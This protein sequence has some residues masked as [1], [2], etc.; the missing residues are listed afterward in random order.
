MYPSRRPR[1]GGW[2]QLETGAEPASASM[3]L[4]VFFGSF[5][6]QP[7]DY[8]TTAQA[9]RF[10][11]RVD[12]DSL[13]SRERPEPESKTEPKARVSGLEADGNT[14]AARRN[15]RRRA[16]VEWNPQSAFPPPRPSP[17]GRRRPIRRRRA[18]ETWRPS[19]PCLLYTSP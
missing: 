3:A 12:P 13:R 7:A 2:P 19:K 15:S 5:A 16:H 9:R 4:P 18:G 8:L 17:L 1:S 6:G 14:R 11:D 10:R